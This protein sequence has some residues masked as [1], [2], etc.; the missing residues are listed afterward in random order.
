MLCIE[1]TKDA[2][3]KLLINQFAIF[4]GYKINAQKS[5][6]FLY[7]NNRKK[8]SERQLAETIPLSIATESVKYISIN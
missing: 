3:R 7:T 1:N 5:P 8:T 6:E 2:T 4:S